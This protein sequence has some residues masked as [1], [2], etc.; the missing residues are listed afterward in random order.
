MKL[1]AGA[2]KHQ[3][4]RMADH[5]TRIYLC[6]CQRSSPSSSSSL[7]SRHLR[8]VVVVVCLCLISSFIRTHTWTQTTRRTATSFS[9]AVHVYSVCPYSFV[10]RARSTHTH[11]HMHTHTM[12]NGEKTK[13]NRVQMVKAS[14]SVCSFRSRNDTAFRAQSHT[15]NGLVR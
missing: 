10:H 14:T 4:K 15:V 13:R 2:A 6:F 3:P 5:F 11:T 7:C 1:S 9:R 12:A 8:S